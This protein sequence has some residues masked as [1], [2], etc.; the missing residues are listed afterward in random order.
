VV[1]K[2]TSF[3]VY[4][5]VTEPALKSIQYYSIMQRPLATTFSMQEPL[6]I[7]YLS[8]LFYN[9]CQSRFNL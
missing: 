7:I 5:T 6:F 1:I 9:S 8:N 3:I 2:C 4:V